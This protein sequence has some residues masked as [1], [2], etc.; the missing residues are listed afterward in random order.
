MK[1]TDSEVAG[2]GGGGAVRDDEL[3][4]V[5]NGVDQ[6]GGADC[7]GAD[8]CDGKPG[9]IGGDAAGKECFGSGSADDPERGHTGGSGLA[10]DGVVD[11]AV[12]EGRRVG[13]A[14]A[15]QPDSSCDE[16]GAID[17]ER[18]AASV[19]YQGCDDAG[20]D[21]RGGGDTA[22]GSAVGGCDCS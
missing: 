15:A 1:K 6:R 10:T 11:C 21:H 8:S 13:T 9:G 7:G 14:G 16:L 3:D 4:G 20:E 17:A 19:A 18:S 5:L 12:S 2:A 22:F